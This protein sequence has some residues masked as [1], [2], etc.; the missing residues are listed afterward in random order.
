MDIPMAT[1]SKS[2]VP[3]IDKDNAILAGV[4]AGLA[5]SFGVSAIYLRISFLVLFASHGWGGVLY[6]CCWG[7]FAW[8]GY[9]DNELTTI[10][11]AS[12]SE[13]FEKVLGLVL[14]VSGSVIL[15][16]AMGGL[17]VSQL[18]PAAIIG[19]GV[20]LSARRIEPFNSVG[21]FRILNLIVGV[22]FAG[23][24][25]WL[26]VSAIGFRSDG[27]AALFTTFLGLVAV[28]LVAAPWW[29]N[30]IKDFDSARQDRLLS[31]ERADV[32]AHLHDSVLQTLALIQ[33][34]KDPERVST[35]ARRQERELRNWLDPDRKSRSAKSIRGRLDEVISELEDSFDISIE[36]VT[37]G[38]YLV[39]NSVESLL[40]ATREAINNACKHSEASLVDVYLEV[41]GDSIS[42]FVRDKGIGFVADDVEPD[43]RGISS[44]IK[45][46]MSK[47]GGTANIE[48]IVGVGTEVEL[49][50]PLIDEGNS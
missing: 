5:N 39:N 47:I 30:L 27:Q 36:L 42:I 9:Q 44:S 34:E 1:L 50:L 10:R 31:D 13:K 25:V 45:R 14:F 38:D 2:R 17:P 40:G 48:S 35:I 19:L 46:R 26:Y 33:K 8:S 6:L 37:V 32:A 15:T 20:M 4:A 43:R 18:L 3:L 12:G 22:G 11:M 49:V 23:L 29:R 7:L 16:Q 21:N 24:G 41:A 28:G